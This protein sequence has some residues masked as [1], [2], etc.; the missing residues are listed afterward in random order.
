MCTRSQ[1]LIS[2]Q[3]T[4]QPH[5]QRHL[6]SRL[7]SVWLLISP[8]LHS[9]RHHTQSLIL[10]SVSKFLNSELF[11]ISVAS[12]WITLASGM[13]AATY[14]LYHHSYRKVAGHSPFR[15]LIS[16]MLVPTISWWQAL[17]LSRYRIHNI[18]SQLQ[19]WL[20]CKMAARVTRS[21]QILCKKISSITFHTQAIT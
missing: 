2:S 6:R 21:R 3:T 7:R 18:A 20:L 19:L 1:S 5:L 9:R 12:L 14:G 16:M 8:K 17:H 10:K 15:L 11:L 13:M 4:R